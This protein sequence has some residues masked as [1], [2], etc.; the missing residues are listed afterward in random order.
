MVFG[1]ESGQPCAPGGVAREDMEA[2]G[3]NVHRLESPE[4]EAV[5]A[6]GL[7]IGGFG[8][9]GKVRLGSPA[10]TR[11]LVP[12]VRVGG[13]LFVAVGNCEFSGLSG[14]LI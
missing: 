4:L 5:D 12:R 3:G 8:E 11:P 13:T 10:P 1:V 14:K 6:V 7:I 9:M 2:M